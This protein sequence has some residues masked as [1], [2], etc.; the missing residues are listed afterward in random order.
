[1]NLKTQQD[2]SAELNKN[3]RTASTVFQSQNA[4]ERMGNEIESPDQVVQTQ[5]D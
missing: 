4:T 2:Q 3:D 1:M 5:I